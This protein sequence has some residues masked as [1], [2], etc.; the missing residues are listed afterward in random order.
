MEKVDAHQ[1]FWKCDPVRDSWITE[2]KEVIRHDF[3]S[4]DLK[5]LLA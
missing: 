4:H 3:L 1:Y 2:E 5:P